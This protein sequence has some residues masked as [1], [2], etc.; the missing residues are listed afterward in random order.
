MLVLS[1]E[2]YFVCNGYAKYEHNCTCK[3]DFILKC[4]YIFGQNKKKDR[5]LLSITGSCVPW[6]YPTT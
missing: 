2:N 1:L 6:Q 5:Q 3:L 4:Q